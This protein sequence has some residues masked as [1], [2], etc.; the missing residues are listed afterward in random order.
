MVHYNAACTFCTLNRKADA[1]EAMSKAWK[2]GYR[3]PV[4]ARL[5]PDLQLLHGEPEFERLYPPVPGQ[6]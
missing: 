4:W 2:A 6:A 3:D 5:D 1:M